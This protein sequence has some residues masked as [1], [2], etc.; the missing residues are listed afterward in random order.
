[1][2][3]T[4][5]PADFKVTAKFFDNEGHEIYIIGKIDD[6][7]WTARMWDGSRLI[8]DFAMFEGEA[9]FYKVLA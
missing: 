8:G 5:T 2:T 6:G 3:R 9:R 7:I 4:A 1:M